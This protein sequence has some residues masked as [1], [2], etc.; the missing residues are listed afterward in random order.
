MIIRINASILLAKGGGTMRERKARCD[1]CRAWYVI[2]REWQRFCCDHCR[3]TW[4]NR[5]RARIVRA[6][7]ALENVSE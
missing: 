7:S 3:V 1:H 5:D 4:H 6:A 2:R